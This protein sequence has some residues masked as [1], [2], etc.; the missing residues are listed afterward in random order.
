MV[1]PLEIYGERYGRLVAIARV[2]N[3]GRRTVWRFL[4]DCGCEAD[5]SL[6]AVRAGMTRSCGCLLRETTA[7]R[8]VTHGHSRGRR[9]TRE[10]KSWHHAKARCYNVNDPKFPQYGGRGITMCA[11]WRNDFGAFIAHMGPAPPRHT[12]DRIDVNGNYEP[13]NCRWATSHQQARGRT[14]NVFV[15]FEGERMILKD[16]AGRAGVSYKA[17]HHRF[18]VLGQPLEQAIAALAVIRSGD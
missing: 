16:C 10:L 17:L 8:S 2:A 15:E 7:T 6:E 14:D 9:A 4:C 18:R 13:G 11:E 5:I 1:A 12:I 3:R